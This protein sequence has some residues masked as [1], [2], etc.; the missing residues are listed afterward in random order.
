MRRMSAYRSRRYIAGIL[1]PDHAGDFACPLLEWSG[2]PNFGRVPKTLPFKNKIDM[3]FYTQWQP[4]PILP[5]INSSPT[6]TVPDQSMTIQ[7][8]IARF[9]RTGSMP[10]S[11][12]T[13]IGDNEAFEPEFDP[14]DVQP[15]E[16]IS[17]LKPAEKS[18]EKPKETASSETPPKDDK[19]SE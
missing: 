9:V 5:E 10:V 4:K 11:L 19:P 18:P 8:I 13:D 17:S 16:V 6:E 1:T 14:L 7:E 12:H 15:S 2:I 3:K